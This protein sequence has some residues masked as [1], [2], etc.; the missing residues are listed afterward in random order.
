MSW[1]FG[2]LG[3]GEMGFGE[4]GFRR[5]GF[6][7]LGFG[8]LGGRHK[9]GCTLSYICMTINPTRSVNIGQHKSTKSTLLLLSFSSIFKTTV[10]KTNSPVT[11]DIFNFNVDRSLFILH[12]HIF[13]QKIEF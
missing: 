4:L 7:E 9:I 13:Q 5:V 2:E 12:A 3:F 6:G 8:E 1:D 11:S 10:K